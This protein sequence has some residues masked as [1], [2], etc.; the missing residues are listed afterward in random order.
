MHDTSVFTTTIGCRI[1]SSE[2]WLKV[3]H[4][5]HGSINRLTS[6]KASVKSSD[7]IHFIEETP[8]RL[9]NISFIRNLHKA[10]NYCQ[11]PSSWKLVPLCHKTCLKE[12]N[13]GRTIWDLSYGT[14]TFYFFTGW[15]CCDAMKRNIFRKINFGHRNGFDEDWKSFFF[16]FV[17]LHFSRQPHK[18]SYARIVFCSSTPLIR[19]RNKCDVSWR[20]FDIRSLLLRNGK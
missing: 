20:K 1:W 8:K 18:A 3:S 19:P 13:P 2:G 6:F 4:T 12:I 5:G 9:I 16:S 7:L 14:E 15:L 17:S 11:K 10:T